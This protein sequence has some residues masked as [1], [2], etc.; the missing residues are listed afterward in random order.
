MEKNLRQNITLH[1]ESYARA[2]FI[3]CRQ[4]GQPSS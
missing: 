2:R 4:V 3:G 1:D